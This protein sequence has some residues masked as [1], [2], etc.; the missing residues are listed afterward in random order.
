M[1]DSLKLCAESALIRF[2]MA[3][4]R[5]HGACMHAWSEWLLVHRAGS[6]T[7]GVRCYNSSGDG[8]ALEATGLRGRHSSE[9]GRAR[10]DVLTSRVAKS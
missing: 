10:R 4:T 2:A 7:C 8:I 9:G 6:A 1:L 3:C 5:Q